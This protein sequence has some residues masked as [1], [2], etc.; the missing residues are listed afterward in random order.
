MVVESNDSLSGKPFRKEDKQIIGELSK[1]F[2]RSLLRI[3]H[4]YC[5]KPIEVLQNRGRSLNKKRRA[6]GCDMTM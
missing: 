6:I 2:K 3:H 5:F 1:L 4:P